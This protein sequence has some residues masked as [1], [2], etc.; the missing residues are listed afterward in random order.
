MNKTTN[1]FNLNQQLETFLILQVKQNV[2]KILDNIIPI[3]NSIIPEENKQQLLEFVDKIT[4]N[5]QQ[6]SFNYFGQNLAVSIETRNSSTATNVR[7]FDA[8]QKIE[9]EISSNDDNTSTNTGHID[10]VSSIYIPET[11]YEDT[12]TD[13]KII[14]TAYK[15]DTFFSKSS[16]NQ[17]IG[18]YIMS[19]SIKGQ[20]IDNLTA[21]IRLQFKINEIY[22]ASNGTCVFWEIGKM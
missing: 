12:Q 17:T 6:P 15:K 21:P 5:I 19:A 13:I 10:P 22:D 1:N 8:H 9:I 18:S 16:T 3:N 11:T 4:K 20:K 14:S 2:L 7:S